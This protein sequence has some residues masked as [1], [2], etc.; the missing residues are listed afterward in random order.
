MKLWKHILVLG[1]GL[2][3]ATSQASTIA[4]EDDF[5][6][7]DFFSKW[8]LT[9]G[10]VDVGA[11]GDLCDNGAGGVCVDTEGTG[12][13]T[14]ARF[15]TASTFSLTQGT[16]YVFSF[17]YANNA[18]LAG[19]GDN[20][21][22][23]GIVTFPANPALSILTQSGTVNSGSVEDLSYERF[24]H[25]FT[26][27]TPFLAPTVDAYIFFAQV[28]SEGDWGGTILDNVRLAEAGSG[29]DPV[30]AP[31][32]AALLGLGLLLGG[33]RRRTR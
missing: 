16:E 20:V 29:P 22:A 23:W 30:P 8:T 7:N 10:G 21:L 24:E 32:P 12:P 13:G 19:G 6:G 11:L 2:F 5:E 4:F 15:Q 33:L 3:A 25:T 1:M 18:G 17:D 9:G 14:N 28:G 27:F 31:A 26:L